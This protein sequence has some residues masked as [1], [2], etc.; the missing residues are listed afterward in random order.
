[1]NDGNNGPNPFFKLDAVSLN[2][3]FYYEFLVSNVA[4][5]RC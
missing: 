4:F 1:M 5:S 2:D 3:T